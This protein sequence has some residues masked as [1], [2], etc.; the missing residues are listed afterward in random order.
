MA[1][2]TAF[3]SQLAAVDNA[4]QA[5]LLALRTMHHARPSDVP[6]MRKV[7]RER[8]QLFVDLAMEAARPIDG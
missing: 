2:P 7:L 5:T 3:D 6:A 8:L 1:L 4:A